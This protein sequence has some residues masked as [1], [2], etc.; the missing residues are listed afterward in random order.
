MDAYRSPG[1]LVDDNNNSVSNYL[2]IPI[3]WFFAAGAD[4][5]VHKFRRLFII[6]ETSNRH[7]R[8]DKVET[9][10]VLEHGAIGKLYFSMYHGAEGDKPKSAILTLLRN[11]GVFRVMW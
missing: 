8:Q 4:D 9:E 3:N 10:V 11:T 5:A 2:L 7:N 1:P 6:G